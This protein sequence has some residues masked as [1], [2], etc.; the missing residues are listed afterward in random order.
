LIEVGKFRTAKASIDHIERHH[1]RNERVPKPKAGAPGKN[2]AAGLGR[3]HFILFFKI[4][5][6]RLPPLRQYTWHQ[7]AHT[8]TK[9]HGT[10][11]CTDEVFSRRG[12]D[13]PSHWPRLYSVPTKINTLTVGSARQMPVGNRRRSF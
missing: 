10:N 1:V 4:T 8:D 12:A 13:R 3:M 9:Q 7:G 6:R 2:N 5:N 11:A